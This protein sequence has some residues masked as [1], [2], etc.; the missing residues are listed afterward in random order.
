MGGGEGVTAGS[1]HIQNLPASQG[2]TTPSESESVTA[3]EAGSL[4]VSLAQAQPGPGPGARLRVCH[5]AGIA[6]QAAAAHWQPE[7]QPEGSP[8]TGPPT[9]AV[10]Q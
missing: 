6:R 1:G 2:G 8:V 5:S 10:T 3:S 7:C 9:L 4:P